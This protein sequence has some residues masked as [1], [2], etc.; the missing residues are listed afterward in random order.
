MN[1]VFMGTQEH[2]A[3]INELINELNDLCTELY[4]AMADKEDSEVIEICNKMI[5]QLKS[6]QIDHTNE[7]LLQ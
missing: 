6:I 3:Y 2:I 1:F 7:T 4:E 5:K